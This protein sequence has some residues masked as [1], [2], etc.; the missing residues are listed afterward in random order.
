MKTLYVYKVETNTTTGLLEKKL[1]WYAPFKTNDELVKAIQGYT[2]A[3][4]YCQVSPPI[5]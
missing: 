3:G 2:L 4:Y 1:I 5:E